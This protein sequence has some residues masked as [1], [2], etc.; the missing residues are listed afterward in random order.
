M[1]T[2]ILPAYHEKYA[3]HV[4]LGSL[5]CQTNP[6]W[7]AIVFHNGD[8]PSD[9]VRIED[10]RI[11]YHHSLVNTGTDLTSRYAAL[12]E[13]VDTE[14]VTSSSIQDFYMPRTVEYITNKIEHGNDFIYWDGMNHHYHDA[15]VMDCKPVIR[16]IDWCNFA[17]R[18]SILKQIDFRNYDNSFSDGRVAEELFAMPIRSSKIQKMLVVHN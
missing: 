8:Y 17:V 6:N 7:K 18:T 1:I 9:Y 12:H 4:S 2:F 5:L 3:P 15:I 14:F 10:E 11:K 13:L 16:R